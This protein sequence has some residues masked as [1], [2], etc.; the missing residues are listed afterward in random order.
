MRRSNEAAR[1]SALR[2]LNLLD[3]PPSESFDRITRMAGQI[4]GLPISAVSLTDEDRQ[5]F[6]SR[7]GVDHDSIPRDKAPCAAVAESAVPIVVPDLLADPCYATSVLAGTGARFYAGTPL[8]TREGHGLGALCV[9]GTEPR[10]ATAKEM[11]ALTDLAAMVMAQIE[12]QHAFGRVEPVSGLPNRNQF[13]EDLSDKARDHPGEPVLIVLVDLARAEQ[14]SNMTGVL[15][16]TEVDEMIRHAARWLR[17]MSAVQHAAYHVSATQFAL[18]VQSDTSAEGFGIMLMERLNALRA[19]SGLRFVTTTAI[20]ISP[21]SLGLSSPEDALRMAHSAVIDARETQR[22]VSIY[23]HVTDQAHRRRYRLLDD[24]GAALDKDRDQLRIVV[25]PRIDLLSDMCVGAEVLLRWRHP[26]LGDVSPAEFIPAVERSALAK[27]TTEWVLQAGLMQIAEWQAVGLDVPLSI[28][29]S[30][31][32]LEEPDFAMR[33]QLYLLKHNVRSEMLELELTESAIMEHPEH[34]LQQMN[35]LKEAGV[36]IA[37]DD[38]GTGHSSLAYLQRLPADVVKIDQSFV[39][40]ITNGEREAQ[41]VRSMISLS[42]GL[43]FRVVAEGVETAGVLD[44]LR[45]MDCDE[46]QGYLFARPMETAR[47]APWL[48]EQRTAGMQGTCML[49]A[50]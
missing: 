42:H 20:G 35:A 17:E 18:I 13:Y 4:F 37:I 44:A 22:G 48:K 29:I 49:Q 11:A 50:G 41:L 45:G 3:T 33:V 12:L 7:L 6:K 23:S 32:N 40:D 34:A 43:G 39:R 9:I 19:G 21:I 1:L 8:V 5:W 10:N 25:Q 28:N 2:Q 27:R 38:F 24:F 30:A 16:S 31:A 15:G 47:F 14:I 26:E 46:V 36:K